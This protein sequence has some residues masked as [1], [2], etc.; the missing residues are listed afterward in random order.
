MLSLRQA[1]LELSDRLIRGLHDQLGDQAEIITPLQPQ[2][3]GCQL[4]LRIRAGQAAGRRLLE[5]LEAHG[6]VCDWRAPD[7][8]RVAP[9]PLYNTTDDVERFINLADRLLKADQN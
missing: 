4:S 8:I 7:I 9:A 1:A 6:V 3:R 2:Q 5:R